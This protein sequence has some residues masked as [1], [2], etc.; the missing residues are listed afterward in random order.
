MFLAERGPAIY[1]FTNNLLNHSFNNTCSEHTV[2]ARP[3]I[4]CTGSNIPEE[5]KKKEKGQNPFLRLTI[6][7]AWGQQRL[8]SKSKSPCLQMTSDPKALTLKLLGLSLK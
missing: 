4:R 3:G 8:H 6:A 1:L 5:R 7:D 2:G